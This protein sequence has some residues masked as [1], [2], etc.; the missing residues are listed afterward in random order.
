MDSE[1]NTGADDA[2][3][4]DGTVAGAQLRAAREAMRLDL[5]HVAAETRIPLR[6]LEAIEAGDFESLPSRTYAI[7]FSRTFAR[8]V[9]LDDVMITEAVRAELATGTMRRS[10]AGTVMEPGDPAKLPSPGLAW[11]GA[12]AALL[13][14]VGAIAFFN[15]YFGAGTQPG[16]LLQADTAQ[17]AAA[18]AA[19]PSAATGPA[20]APPVGGEVVLTATD[21]GVWLRLYEASGERLAERTLGQGETLSVPAAAAD[22]RINTGRPDALA[23]TIGG[24]SVA[25]LSDR[26]VTIANAPVSAAALLARAEPAPG[27]AAAP[28]SAPTTTTPASTST[29]SRPVTRRSTNTE[30]RSA[31]RAATTVPESADPAP[32]SVSQTSP[33][34]ASAEPASVPTG[35]GPTI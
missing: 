6:H 35:E 23:I 1:D 12:F 10:E 33:A 3:E 32:V 28:T 26:P 5:A 2:P 4:A 31:Q 34:A 30:T 11:A 21:D 15:A 13:L 27:P 19:A 7:G 20:T 25:R 29:T 16:S 17:P 22:P 8:A 24:K 18:T 9:G 14:A